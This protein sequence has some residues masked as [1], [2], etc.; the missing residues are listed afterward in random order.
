MSIASAEPVAYLS[1][2]ENPG[3]YLIHWWLL[4]TGGWAG[5]VV[6]AD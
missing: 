5:V 2:N 4:Q 1:D 6:N 3:D